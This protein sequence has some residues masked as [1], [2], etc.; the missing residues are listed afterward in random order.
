MGADHADTLYARGREVAW[1]A[2]LGS[3]EDALGRARKLLDDRKRVLGPDHLH[4]LHARRQVARL[5]ERAEGSAAAM[6]V[7]RET[8]DE[9]VRILGPDHP[10]TRK[11]LVFSGHRAG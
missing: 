2:A 6:P 9:H 11:V 1:L 7:W 4:T 3:Y 10:L 8:L 5:A